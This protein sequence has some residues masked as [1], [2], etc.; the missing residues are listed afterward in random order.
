MVK[1]ELHA[2]ERKKQ[3]NQTGWFGSNLS[4]YNVRN[5]KESLGRRGRQLHKD[6]QGSAV[7]QK[8][9]Y[10]VTDPNIQDIIAIERNTIDEGPRVN[11]V[12]Q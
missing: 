3:Q 7:R 5:F 4:K 2:A 8:A 9:T 1:N 10:S 6:S 12:Y 11:R